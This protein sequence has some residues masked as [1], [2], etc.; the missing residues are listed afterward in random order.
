VDYLADRLACEPAAVIGPDLAHRLEAAGVEPDLAAAANRH[1]EAGV[2]A[3]YAGGDAPGVLDANTV[4]D[5][6]ERL[7]ASSMK[8]MAVVL[9]LVV[10]IGILSA[11]EPAS[12]GEAA[13]RRGDYETATAS[14]RE[15]AAGGDRRAAYNLGNSL[16]RQGRF[17][18]ALAAYERARLAAPRDQE[19]LFNIRLTRQ[20]LDLVEGEGEPFLDTLAELRDRLRPWER[21]WLCSALNL[22]AAVFVLLGGRRL[23]A[24]GVALAL[25]AL[26]LLLEVAWWGPARPPTGIV[27]APKVALR[28]EPKAELAALMTLRAG[29]AVAVLQEGPAWTRVRLR[30]REGYLPNRSL[31]VVR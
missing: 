5:L 20:K 16:Y 18:E 21:L 7:E 3:R 25:P 22:L 28:S 10:A 23:R 27:T 19:L 29:V 15:Q 14:F 2:S 31:E 17:A 4:R 1:V 6:V 13:Y 12:K 8:P 9:G 30:D 24:V 26:L 11:Q